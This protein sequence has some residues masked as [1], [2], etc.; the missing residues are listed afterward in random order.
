M[1]TSQFAFECGPTV[2]NA[3]RMGPELVRT[4]LRKYTQLPQN[5][6]VVRIGPA[7]GENIEHVQAG[8]RYDESDGHQTHWV[9]G[10]V[11]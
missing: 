5:P 10:G 6:G 9:V 7:V 4:L 11:I 2:I 3:E 1:T 8:R